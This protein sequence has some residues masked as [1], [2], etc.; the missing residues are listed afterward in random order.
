MQKRTHVVVSI[1]FVSLLT[2]SFASAFSI[3]SFFQSFFGGIT[4]QAVND[5][6]GESV[7]CAS[8]TLASP[9]ASVASSS[10]PS[11]TASEAIDGNANTFWISDN[12]TFPYWIYFDLGVKK[13]LNAVELKVPA[14]STPLNFTVQVSD[15]AQTWTNVDNLQVASSD[16]SL[17]SFSEKTARYIR[18]HQLSANAS[19]V[20][21][22]DV[23]VN[24]SAITSSP[25]SPANT[26]PSVPIIP[27]VQV[28]PPTAENAEPSSLCGSYSQILP[29][30]A[31]ASSQFNNYRATNAID[32]DPNTHWFGD[33]KTEYPKWIAFDLGGKKCI[34]GLDL[35]LFIWD[36]PVTLDVEVSDDGETWKRV[37]SSLTIA[38][39]GRYDHRDLPETIARYVR[40]NELSGR[41]TYGSLSEIKVMAAPLSITAQEGATFHTQDVIGSSAPEKFYLIKG[42]RFYVEVDGKIVDEYF[43]KV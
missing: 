22:I 13:C 28:T 14:N 24:S 5:G 11:H 18:M 32:D 10:L 36:A 15:D 26:A 2:L 9:S 21:L 33:P 38:E 16:I 4:G 20:S 25:A 31:A 6:S 27:P 1:V 39:G 8:Y 19:D 41:R 7:I 30:S 12:V 23:R 37:K 35:N 3:S 17:K 42:S 29:R 43:P 40:I 34:N